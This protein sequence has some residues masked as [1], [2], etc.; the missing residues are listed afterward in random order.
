LEHHGKVD[1]V[2]STREIAEELNRLADAG[3]STISESDLI[4]LA[5]GERAQREYDARA[6][7]V[8]RMA[9]AKTEAGY[10]RSAVFFDTVWPAALAALKVAK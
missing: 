7:I 4:G 3:Q 5:F 8:L 10:P 9:R 6:K 2:K 1:S